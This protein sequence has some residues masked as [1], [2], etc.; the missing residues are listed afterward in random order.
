LLYW[1]KGGEKKVISEPTQQS[2]RIIMAKPI[3]EGFHAITPTLVFKDARKAIT[4]YQE[5]F[6]AKELMAMPA[7]D[8][9]GVMHAELK[10]GDS[11]IMLSDERPEMPCRSAETL[12]TSPVG[13]FLYVNDVD[14]AFKKAVEA[15]GKQEM[16][17][18]DMFWG[19]R[20]G[21]LKDP[22]GYNWMMATRKK[23]LTPEEMA[24]GAEAFF[25]QM[26]N[27]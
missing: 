18:Q 10:V 22:F 24:K 5:A 3:P 7:P 14:T 4:F 13:F 6:G 11:T 9:K 19:D 27:K 20:A 23:D 12:G 26:A 17:V 8:G 21:S 16:P 1:E 15:G 2:R 25:A